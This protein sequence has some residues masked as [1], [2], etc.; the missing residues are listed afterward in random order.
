MDKHEGR[1]KGEGGAATPGSLGEK[2][3]NEK[4]GPL[5]WFSTNR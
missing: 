5:S 2:R 4:K 1:K 3:G